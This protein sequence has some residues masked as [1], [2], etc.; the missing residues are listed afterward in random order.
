M[1]DG[2]LKGGG[3]DFRNRI[4]CRQKKKKKKKKTCTGVNKCI[5]KV[6]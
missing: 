6:T 4:Q 1:D 2:A 5:D 3:I